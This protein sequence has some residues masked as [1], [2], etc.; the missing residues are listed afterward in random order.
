[1]GLHGSSQISGSSEVEPFG[2]ANVAHPPGRVRG[3]MEGCGRPG[4]PATVGDMDQTS[5]VLEATD[6]VVE[7]ELLIEEI[8]IDGMC[9]VY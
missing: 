1:L 2:A 7:D 8:S 4:R 6:V 3:H 5:A 9:G